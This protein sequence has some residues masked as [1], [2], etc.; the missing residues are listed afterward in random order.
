MNT[1]TT[2]FLCGATMALIIALALL[3]LPTPPVTSAI[4]TGVDV[5]VGTET[6]QYSGPGCS[7]RDAIQTINNGANHGGC[8]RVANFTSFNQVLVPAGIYAL[9]LAGSGED[10]NVTGDLDIRTNMIISA[11]GAVTV[12]GE[13]GWNDRI[14]HIITG[15]E[16]VTMKGL[17]VSGGSSPFGGGIL[18]EP[19][20]SLTLNDGAVESNTSITGG[21]IY[22]NQGTLTLNNTTVHGNNATCGNCLSDGGGIENYFGT[23][24]LTNV[25]L[26]NNSAGYVGGGIDTFSGEMMLTNVTISGNNVSGNSTTDSGGGIH[27]GSPLTL[28][29]VTI[30]NNYAPNGGGIYAWFDTVRLF[31]VTLSGNSAFAS[32]GGGINRN[33]PATIMILNTIVANSPTGGNCNTTIGGSY[34]LSD[35]NTCGFGL[36]DNIPVMLG[37]LA[38]NGGPT[39]THALLPGSPAIDAIPLGTSGC[40]TTITTDQRGFPRPIDG[41]CDIGAYER[42]VFLYLPLVL[43]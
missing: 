3:A 20:T 13:P 32:N 21:G 36:G 9:T 37:P 22:N 39:L 5:S 26:S 30:S 27:T 1:R 43:K 38:N 40:G 28:T 16:R 15:T 7:L 23:T 10:F 17:V 35:D 25:T 42:G 18:V 8:F 6:D 41:R 31:N 34:N 4:G 19:G 11:T 14:F 12:T 29:N 2:R 33:G 24:T